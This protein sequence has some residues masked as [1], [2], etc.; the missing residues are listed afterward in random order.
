VIWLTR[1]LAVLVALAV[2]A[3][4]VLGSSL[5]YTDTAGDGAV[6]RL[7]WRAVGEPI[8]ECREPTE[9]ELAALPPH[10]RR[11]EICEARLSAFRLTVSIDNALVFEGDVRPEGARGDRPA[12]VFHEFA[13]APGAH[14][15]A[16]R[17]ET[18]R[19]GRAGAPHSLT[20]LDERV[21]LAPREIRLVT[22][23]P[24][25]DQLDLRE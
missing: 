1:S 11:R 17:F 25:T 21:V 4:I 9:A 23:E 10:M 7:S 14:R 18:E 3:G 13:V 2:T 22:L 15:L 8:E 24:G 6:I 20:T 16:I 5:P 12:Y 19:N